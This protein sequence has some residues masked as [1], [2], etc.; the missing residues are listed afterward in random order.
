MQASCAALSGFRL[1]E[2]LGQV[3]VAQESDGTFRS[4]DLLL[5]GEGSVTE[6]PKAPLD[7]LAS[8]PPRILH[9]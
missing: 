1:T 9:D 7:A 8:K 2:L 5:Y 4:G 6:R 3:N